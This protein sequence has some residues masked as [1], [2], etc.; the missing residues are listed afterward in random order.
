MH[1]RTDEEIYVK[2]PSDI[3]SSEF[4]RL[5]AA[6]NGPRKASKHCKESSSDKLVT[7]MIFQQNN[8]N[9]TIYKRLQHGDDVLVVELASKLEILAEEFNSRFSRADG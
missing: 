7:K 4:W 3:R 5:Q 1:A 9:S 6:V 8:M 2:V